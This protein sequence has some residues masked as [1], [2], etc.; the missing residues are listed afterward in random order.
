MVCVLCCLQKCRRSGRLILQQ[1]AG[2][3]CRRAFARRA[4][5]ARA[6][7]ALLVTHSLRKILLRVVGKQKLLSDVAGIIIVLRDG[8]HSQTHSSGWLAG[9]R[10][11]WKCEFL[12]GIQL[13]SRK[14]RCV[15]RNGNITACVQINLHFD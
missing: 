2:L 5:F 11:R 7:T 8:T 13:C 10:R 15:G 6:A 9:E 3:I 4:L 1:R 12:W 14:I